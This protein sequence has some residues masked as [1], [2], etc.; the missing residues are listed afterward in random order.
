MTFKHR[1]PSASIA[2]IQRKLRV[3]QAGGLRRL[4]GGGRAKGTR[5]GGTAGM[6]RIRDKSTLR[7]KG[8]Q[9]F[10][11]ELAIRAHMNYSTDVGGGV[12]I[13]PQIQSFKGNSFFQSGP[14]TSYGGAYSTNAPS[15]LYYLLSSTS[16]AGAIA[17]YQQYRITSSRINLMICLNS[18]ATNIPVYVFII[19]STKATLAGMTT[20]QLEEQPYC[21]KILM[22]ASNTSGKPTRI[23]HSMRSTTV[24]GDM[25]VEG[26]ENAYEA[27][28]V[29]DPANLWFW[30]TE[31]RAANGVQPF[32]LYVDYEIQY[33]VELFN[34]NQFVTTVPV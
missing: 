6:L 12:A 15:G 20:T 22:P 17:P 8:K 16:A 18:L 32:D 30:H 24:W 10:P 1:K 34:L 7:S 14:A 9:I 25:P 28:A 31:F 26:E 5:G 4:T 13:G 23:S 21:K 3:R 33:N 11:H 29:A 27:T 2:A 19:P